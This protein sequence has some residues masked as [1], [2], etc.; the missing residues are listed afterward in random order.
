MNTTSKLQNCEL[1]GGLY[2]RGG[3]EYEPLDHLDALVCCGGL[4]CTGSPFVWGEIPNVIIGFQNIVDSAKK[5]DGSFDS[6]ANLIR[7]SPR[8][9]AGFNAWPERSSRCTC[10]HWVCTAAQLR[11]PSSAPET[12]KP[13][14]FGDLEVSLN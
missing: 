10:Q 11:I 8:P 9:T 6:P 7:T 4:H 3:K 13:L 2:L 12:L 1:F 5:G 14:R